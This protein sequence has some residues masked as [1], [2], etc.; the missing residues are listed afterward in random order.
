VSTAATVS[1]LTFAISSGLDAQRITRRESHGEVRNHV[2]APTV[3]AAIGN[4]SRVN[5][6]VDGLSLSSDRVRVV[7]VRPNVRTQN[8]SSALSKNAEQIEILRQ[9][10]VTI[11][12][13]FRKLAESRPSLTVDDVVAAGILDVIETGKSVNV[14]VLY[15]DIRN[16]IGV[17]STT[18]GAVATF[19]PTSSSLLSAL[20]VAPEMVA[21]VSM[22]ESVRLDHVRFYDIDAILKPADSLT[23]RSAIRQNETSIR[24]LRSELSKR[25]LVMQAM[26][27]H[28]GTL[29]LGDIFAADILGNDDVLV[30]YYKRRVN[31]GGA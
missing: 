12:P 16:R 10:L 19:R 27:R 1:A 28:D 29:M 25:P 18:S 2:T 24:S 7:Y 17:R 8:Y 6:R 13:V 11:E 22:L 23:Y 20:R 26:A 31:A 14:L 15:V 9:E 21:R 3:V 4:T 30:L 5:A